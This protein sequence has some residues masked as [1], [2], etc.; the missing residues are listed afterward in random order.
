MQI[1]TIIWQPNARW[2]ALGEEQKRDYLR[3]LDAP[4]NG[5]RAA[6]MVTLGWSEIDPR[7]PHAPADSFVGVFGAEDAEQILELE[8]AVAQTNWYQYFDSTNISVNLKGINAGEPHRVYA[9]LLDVQT[10]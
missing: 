8:K 10:D 1:L 7:V 5:A 9:G 3:S 2:R 6:G 4:I